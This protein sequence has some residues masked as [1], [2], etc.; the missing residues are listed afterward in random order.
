MSEPASP[1]PDKTGELTVANHKPVVITVL[2][3]AL[4]TTTGE[5]FLRELDHAMQHDDTAMVP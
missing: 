1:N 4:F 5:D 3:M 2:T